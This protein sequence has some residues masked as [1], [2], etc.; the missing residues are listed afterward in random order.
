MFSMLGKKSADNILSYIYV[1]LQKIGSDNSSF[2]CFI[3]VLLNFQQPFSHIAMVSEF[4]R[5]LN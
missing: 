2:V 3:Q 5:E 1:F 4:G